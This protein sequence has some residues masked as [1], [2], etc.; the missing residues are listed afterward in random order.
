MNGGQENAQLLKTSHNK[1]KKQRASVKKQTKNSEGL[2]ASQQ[3]F[4]LYPGVSLRIHK[5]VALQ[6]HST[7]LMKLEK[8]VGLSD[9]MSGCFSCLVCQ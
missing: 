2:S 8:G 7:H 6:M 3:G 4:E 5:T 1:M 9:G